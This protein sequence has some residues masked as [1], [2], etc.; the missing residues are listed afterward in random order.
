MQSLLSRAC[1]HGPHRA[2]FPRSPRANDPLRLEYPP[3]ILKLCSGLPFAGSVQPHTDST[4]RA[5]VGHRMCSGMRPWG[6]A[7]LLRASRWP[8]TPPPWVGQWPTSTSLPLRWPGPPRPLSCHQTSK[9]L[10]HSPASSLPSQQGWV[11]LG[12]SVPQRAPVLPDSPP[13]LSWPSCSMTAAP[14]QNRPEPGPPRLLQ[15]TQFCSP[16]PPIF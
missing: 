12:V 5:L 4:S 7:I 11:P 2:G 10:T 16:L 3:S 9:P 15:P 14:D 13:A 8:P 6:G 1:L